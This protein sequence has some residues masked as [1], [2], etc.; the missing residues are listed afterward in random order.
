MPVARPALFVLG[1]LALL[2]ATLAAPAAQASP[3]SAKGTGRSSVSVLTYNVC[4]HAEACHGWTKRESAIVR[5]IVAS[6]AD[7]VNLQEGWGV[8]PLLEQRLAAHGYLLVASSGNEG[9]FAKAA[10][11]APVTIA[12]PQKDCTPW[13]DYTPPTVDTTKWDKTRPRQQGGHTWFWDE[14]AGAWYRMSQVCRDTVVQVPQA[15]RI[16]LG[17]RAGSALALLRVKRT[18][19]AYMFV[20][21]HLTTGKN[22]VARKRSGETTRLLAATAQIDHGHLRVFA[23][24]FNSSIQRGRDTVGRR[25]RSSGFVDAFTTARSRTA[26]KYN[27]ATGWGTKPRV[28]GSHIDR[29]FLPRG[30]TASRWA[31]DVKTHGGRSVRPVPSDHSPV[32]VSLTLP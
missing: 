25:M 18:N 5:R 23:G 6:R 12:T 28:G 32:R 21:A 13:R 22:R 30:A 14:A 3:V 15:G 24:D 8:L 16:G 27:S 1:V 4:G 31:M 20:N 9:I 26:T 2:T 17:G 7:V 29:V 11:M 10:T 19:K